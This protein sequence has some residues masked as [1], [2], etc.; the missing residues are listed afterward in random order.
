LVLRV[1]P[2]DERFGN[3]C[4][5]GV[6]TDLT[7]FCQLL[8]PRAV[9]WK[10]YVILLFFYCLSSGAWARIDKISK[11]AFRSSSP[12]FPKL[13]IERTTPRHLRA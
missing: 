7:A 4:L 1:G 12:R 6:G 3:S 11:I 8:L 9:G 5:D 2:G 10:L 13:E